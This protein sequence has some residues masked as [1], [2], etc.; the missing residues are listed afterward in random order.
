MQRFCVFARD[1]FSLFYG[2]CD[3]H[4]TFQGERNDLINTCCLVSVVPY[5]FHATWSTNNVEK[6]RPSSF[7]AFFFSF[8]LLKLLLLGYV[9]RCLDAQTVP[10]E[11]AIK[12][13][14]KSIPPGG[15]QQQRT[16]G[17]WGSLRFF[18]STKR[19]L[20]VYDTDLSSLL[21]SNVKWWP[22]I[23]GTTTTRLFFLK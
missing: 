6:R 17:I 1:S 3:R 4:A 10:F 16:M 14:K 5:L 20:Y 22:W 11:A 13:Y 18:S 19:T 8:L 2:C 9:W 21:I 12:S 23:S 7:K 15:R